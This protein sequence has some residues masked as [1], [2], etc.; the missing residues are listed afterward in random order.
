[1]LNSSQFCSRAEV[2][3]PAFISITGKTFKMPVPGPHSQ[4]LIQVPGAGPESLH[5]NQVPSAAAPD[6]TPQ[7]HLCM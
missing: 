7:G 5:F 1:V 6:M 3:T 2:L 4:F